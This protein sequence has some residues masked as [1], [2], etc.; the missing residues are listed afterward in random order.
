MTTGTCF[1]AQAAE[2]QRVEAILL[3]SHSQKVKE[4]GFKPRYTLFG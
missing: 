2:A 3:R 1:P 4:L